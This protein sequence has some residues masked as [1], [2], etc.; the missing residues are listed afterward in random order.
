[1]KFI[2]TIFVILIL[3]FLLI[4][5]GITQTSA[6]QKT[7]GDKDIEIMF[8]IKWDGKVIPGIT[9]VS[10]LKR[11]TDV[12]LNRSG[13]DANLQ[14]RSPGLTQYEPITIQRPRSADREFERWANKVWNFGAGLGSEVSLKD[15]RKDIRI[16]L[17]TTT[18]EILLAFQVYRC[19]PSEYRALSDL[20]ID[21]DSLATES[22]ILQHEGWERDYSV[23]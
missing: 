21:S 11:V 15:F 17:I 12:I 23:E 4:T 6:V 5:S 8:R 9:K 1:M 7:N 13:G 14:R 18:G 20:D 3:P 16:E 19:W 22:L 2:T 10:G